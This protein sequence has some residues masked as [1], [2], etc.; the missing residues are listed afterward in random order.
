MGIRTDVLERHWGTI[1]I[2]AVL[3]AVVA[4]GGSFLWSPRYLAIDNVLVR[5]REARLLTSTGED[6]TK[7]P[8]V[9]DSSVAKAVAQTHS[10]LLA[11]RTLAERVVK[12]LQLDQRKP[13][14][15]FVGMLR[16]AFKQTYRFIVDVVRYGYHAEP[17]AYE[18]AVINVQTSV[19]GRPIKDSYLIEIR[20]S[21]DNAQL[22]AAIAESATKNLIALNQERAQQD[23]L[24]H[25]EFLKEQS[26]RLA[27]GVR[28][29]EKAVQQYKDEQGITDVSETIRLDVQ[30]SQTLQATIRDTEAQLAAARAELDVLRSQ[31]QRLA[32]TETTTSSVATGRST[33]TTTSTTPNR[34]YQDLSSRVAET[35]AKI[36]SLEGKRDALSA[37]LTPGQT[38]TLT[39]NEAKLRELE[40]NLSIANDAYRSVR[41]DYEAALKSTQQGDAEIT[42]VDSPG[43]PLYPQ[44]PQRYLFLAVG[45]LLGLVGG[46]GLAHYLD[47]RAPRTR[48]ALASLPGLSPQP[49]FQ[50][51]RDLEAS[52]P[53]GQADQ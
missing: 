10:N 9:V 29:A 19:E 15:S 52:A 40:L 12:D 26:D 27:A 1:A 42:Q 30:A 24:N 2:V 48:R 38:Q 32:A 16:S 46:T 28:G 36:A 33:T 41:S 8:T 20:A 11:S 22:A 44:S 5:V 21:A 3:S 35:N 6:L 18:G 39:A 25:L 50:A 23:S 49:V 7:Q 13:D 14:E 34:V 43:V 17:S 47:A 51:R 31:L 53:A 45:L 37:M 4:F